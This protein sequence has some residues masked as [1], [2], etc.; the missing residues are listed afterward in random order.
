MVSMW[1]SDST[2]H[3][4]VRARRGTPRD[5]GPHDEAQ[6]PHDVFG[7]VVSDVMW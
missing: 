5:E 4:V 1:T 7:D 2:L 3:G 6:H